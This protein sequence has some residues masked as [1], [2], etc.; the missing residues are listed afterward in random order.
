MTDNKRLIQIFAI[1]LVAVIVVA[2][3]LGYYF[4]RDKAM[5]GAG[6][7]SGDG[8]ES[9]G[10]AKSPTREDVSEDTVVPDSGA[11]VAANVA[12]PESVAP[13]APGVESK[14]RQFRIEVRGGAFVPDTVIVAQGD[15]A[16]IVFVAV[17]GDYDLFQPDYGFRLTLPQGKERLLEAQFPNDGKYLFYC[18]SCGGPDSG[19]TGYIVVVP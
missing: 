1:C 2:G 6:N 4:G 7:G 12:V 16:H 18:P 17:D 5:D 15:I 11:V 19:P 8:S 13:A 14:K 3:G 10:A 9:T